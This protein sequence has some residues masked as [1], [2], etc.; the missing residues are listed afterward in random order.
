[1]DRTLSRQGAG[2][3]RRRLGP[4]LLTLAAL[5]GL[6][7]LYYLLPEPR[8]RVRALPADDDALRA[9][10][11][12]L[13]MPAA[14]L[15]APSGEDKPR[16]AL[17]R[18]LFRDPR[19]SGDGSKA[20]ASCHV[21]DRGYASEQAPSLA[22]AQ[23]STWLGRDGRSDSLAAQALQAAEDPAQLGGSRLALVRLLATSYREEYRQAFGA[24]PEG[25]PDLSG[26]A[27]ARPAPPAL[28]LSIQ[29]AAHALAS[30]GDFDLLSDVL[31]AAQ[32]TRRAPAME[33]SRRAMGA[34]VAPGSPP[35]VAETEA[36]APFAAW[37]ELTPSERAAVDAVFANYGRALAAFERGLVAASSPFDRFAE[38]LAA[39]K[40]ANAAL[41]AGFGPRELIGLR[42]F[43][44]PAG[45]TACHGGPG[46]SDQ[47]F[48]NIGL[49]QRGDA[50][51]IG[52][53]AGVRFVRADPFNCLGEQRVGPADGEACRELPYL[54]SD[55]L[56][57][58]GAFK[59]PSLRNVSATA[60]YMHDGRYGTLRA[61]LD[62]YTELADKPATGRREGT[63]VA[64]D[65]TDEE[66]E[67]LEAFLVSLASPVRDLSAE[68]RVGSK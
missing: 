68:E 54:D 41:D 14:A 15:A 17:G 11:A 23:L 2:S 24:L 59:T 47:E 64:L 50:I 6:A 44:G 18:A 7:A 42:L 27:P 13:M 58:V 29:V 22:N 33:L 4:I 30:L 62:H 67:A 40:P 49:S 36:N 45:C 66:R 21:P 34:P 10:V 43:L 35:T 63:L 1:L 26:N 28:D 5:A 16:A 39:G 37:R 25:L 56:D 12:P 19:L 52:R 31:A 20:C 51:D 9:S 57:L 65:L 3:A 8:P 32:L 55:D 61:V 60:P 46:L 48:H 38:H 53:A